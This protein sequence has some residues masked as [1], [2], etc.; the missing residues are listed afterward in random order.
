VKII[1][2]AI[3]CVF[4][5]CFLEAQ[6]TFQNLDFEQA[7]IV[8]FG[9]GNT[10][11]VQVSAALSHWTAYTGGSAPPGAILYDT[12][13]AGG[14]AL[15]IQDSHSPVV[16][17]LQGNYSV[18]FQVGVAN[19][20]TVA[21]A[22]TGQVPTNSASINFYAQGTANLLLTFG[23]NSIPLTLLGTTPNYSILGGD[24]SAFAGQSG[25]L[26]FT[27]SYFSTFSL[28]NI[29][30]SSQSIPEPSAVAVFGVGTLTLALIRGRFQS[31]TGKKRILRED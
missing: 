7:T 30:F 18:L 19:A 17:P 31:R 29:Q 24:M 25:E 20:S 12:A 10:N 22:Q 4:I 11:L 23:G 21:L 16:Q 2:I 8:P 6:G 26:R 1:V 28:D 9:G 14:P 15:S 5:P 27:A 3:S 13:T